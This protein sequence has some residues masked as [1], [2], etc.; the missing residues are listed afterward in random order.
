M[1]LHDSLDD[2]PDLGNNEWTRSINKGFFILSTSYLKALET[3][4]HDDGEALHLCHHK[5][6]ILMCFIPILEAMATSMVPL[7]W[8]VSCTH[9]FGRLTVE[10]E[11]TAVGAEADDQAQFVKSSLITMHETGHRGWPK[12]VIDVNWLIK[13]CSNKRHMKF[14]FLADVLGIHR[15]TLWYKLKEAGL[16]VRFSTMDDATLVWLLKDFKKCRPE[17]GLRYVIGWLR[18][19]GLCVQKERIWLKWANIDPVEQALWH[20]DRT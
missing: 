18:T 8:I 7:P 10:L 1:N 17:S 20:D 6:R 3:L 14:Q 11:E 12:K 5:E 9:T 16:Q 15:N 19:N 2:L 13:A 4:R